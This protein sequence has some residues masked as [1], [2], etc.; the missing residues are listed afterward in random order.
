VTT[1]FVTGTDTGVGKTTVAASLLT[2]ARNRGWLVGAMKPVESGCARAADGSLVPADG[3]L[4]RAAAGGRDA[5]ERV[6]PYRFE[7]AVAP[8]VAAAADGV[9][10]DWAWVAREVAAL[11]GAV[12]WCLVEGAGGWLVPMGGG[13]LLADVVVGLR[14]PVLVVARAGLGTINHTLLTLE[15]AAARGVDVVGVVLSDPDGGTPDGLGAE[16]AAEIERYGGVRV[17][18]SLGYVAARGLDE[19]GRAAERRLDLDGLLARVG[20]RGRG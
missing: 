8:G 10:I 19:L 9:V 5:L 7:R 14:L 11:A 4:L 6:C 13:R 15:S 12:D 3:T 17:Y 20:Q 18:G 16:N 2:A 1:W